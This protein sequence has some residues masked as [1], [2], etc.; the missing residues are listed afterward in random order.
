MPFQR[1]SD[2]GRSVERVKQ[3]ISSNQCRCDR[4]DCFEKIKVKE[5]EIIQY[6]DSF[7]SMEKAQ[8]DSYVTT[9]I[10]CSS[11]SGFNVLYQNPC[12]SL[13]NI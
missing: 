4:L 9:S 6:L 11:M 12:E 5:P 1:H 2:N 10:L 7:W 13:D 8:Q 3:L